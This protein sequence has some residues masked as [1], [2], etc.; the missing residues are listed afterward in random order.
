MLRMEATIK[1][2]RVMFWTETTIARK[3]GMNNYEDP[4]K[5]CLWPGVYWWLPVGLCPRKRH[6]RCSLC[7]LAKAGEMPSSEQTF[8]WHVWP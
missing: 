6:Y 8:K 3:T 1:A 5:N 2:S 7:G 4:T